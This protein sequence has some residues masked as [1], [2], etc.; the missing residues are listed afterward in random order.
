MKLI[1]LDFDGTLGN[2]RQLI[3]ETMQQTIQELKLAPRT[4]EQC[5]SMIGLPLKQAFT[6][7]IPM[8]NEMGDKCV[9]TYRRI[10]FANNAAYSIPTFPHVI[11]TLQELSSKGY[12]MLWPVAEFVR[13]WWILSIPCIWKTPLPIYWEP[14]M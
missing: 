6:D 3:V 14:M 1:I 13:V 12:T 8:A 10:F 2:T 4:D 9:D 7:L 11:E 5:A